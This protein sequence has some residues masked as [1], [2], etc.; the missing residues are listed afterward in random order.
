MDEDSASTLQKQAITAAL[1]YNWDVA[2]DLNKKMIKLCPDDTDCLNRLARA[3]FELGKYPQAKKIYQEVLTLDPYNVIA[4]KNLK[5]IGAFKKGVV[6][7]SHNGHSQLSPLLFLEEAGITKVLTLV[8][9]AEPQKL[10]MSSA[11]EEVLLQLKN[12]GISVTDMEGNYLGVLPDD[13]SHLLMK[14]I[15]GGNK[16]QA[17]IKSIKPNSLSILVREVFRSK[18]FKNQPSFNSLYLC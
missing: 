16:Y 3:L 14:L 8:K 6:K 18:K 13:A 15:N 1:S 9:L 10:S 17:I 7:T 4:Q 12:R 11:G 5:K 2:V